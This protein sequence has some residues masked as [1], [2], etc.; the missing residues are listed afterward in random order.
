M[1]TFLITL[2]EHDDITNY[3]SKWSGEILKT[4][5]EMNHNTVKLKGSEVNK[6]NFIVR[7]SVNNPNFVML[8]GHGTN[9]SINGH[10]NEILLSS[11]DSINNQKLTK[12]KIIYIRSCSSGAI[13]GP[14]CI[15]A[16]CNVFIGYVKEFAIIR[17]KSKVSRPLEDERAKPF[18]DVSNQI[19]LAILRG[20]TIEEATYKADMRLE[21]E[22]EKLMTTDNFIASHIIPWLLWNQ[23]IRVVLGNAT[24][25]M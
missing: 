15:K 23:K 7:I 21:K 11:K 13:L 6:E 12:N 5:E 17:S 8:N 16:E 2:P 25:K 18:F 20:S 3:C 22:I 9:D 19:P 1:P 10:A 4:S 24:A 14:A